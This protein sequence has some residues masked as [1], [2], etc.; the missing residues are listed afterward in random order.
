M[1]RHGYF[2]VTTKYYLGVYAASPTGPGFEISFEDL[3]IK[4]GV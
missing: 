2:P 1:L 4:N 3:L